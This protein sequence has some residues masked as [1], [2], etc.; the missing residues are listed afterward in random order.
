MDDRTFSRR[1][2]MFVSLVR[3]FA[4]AFFFFFSRLSLKEL[5][6]RQ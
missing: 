1:K 6:E 2:L 3:G 5:N 4:F